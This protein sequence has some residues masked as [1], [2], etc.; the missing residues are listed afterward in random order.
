[1]ETAKEEHWRQRLQ[2]LINH[3]EI[4]QAKFGSET[5]IVPSYVSRLLYPPGKPGR[6]NLGPDTMADIRKRYD[7]APGWFDLP[8][9]SQLP[10]K[11]DEPGLTSARPLRAAQKVASWNNPEWPFA[12]VEPADFFRLTAEERQ[13]IEKD[14]LL[15]IKNREPPSN[16]HQPAPNGAAA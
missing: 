6:K 9:G 10:A 16:Q 14:I 13:H 12:N 11:A 2:E 8:L 15:R 7:L 3:L 4:K 5:G 1:M